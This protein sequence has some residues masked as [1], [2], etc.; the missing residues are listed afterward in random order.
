MADNTILNT[1]AGGD[2]VRDKD[3]AGVKTQ[4]VGIDVAI[5]SGTESLMTSTNGMPVR[6]AVVQQATNNLTAAAQAQTFTLQ[7]EAAMTVQLAGTWVGTVVFEA[8]NDNSN[9]STINA[10]RA[11][12]NTITQT[13]SNTAG[14]DVY[15]LG[16][17]G[18]LFVRTRC[19]AYTSGTI[20][21]T[22]ATSMSAATAVL[23]ASLPAGTAD[24]GG[25]VVGQRQFWYEANVPG[26]AAAV[27]AAGDQFGSLITIANAARI[28]GAGG[29]ITGVMLFD[30]DDL[31]VAADVIFYNDTVTPAADNAVFALS[32]ADGRKALWLCQMPY[33]ADMGA[34][35]AAQVVGVSVPYF[36][37]ATSL[38]A[39]IRT[40]SAVTPTAT[41][42]R[43]RVSMIRD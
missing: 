36:C 11:G 15:R 7:G 40:Q 9:W 43:I 32:D 2:S 22:S 16:I 30:D 20:V 29:F 25:V 28:T 38:Y 5:G 4:I 42:V 19:S 17:A 34:Q 6:S 26:I 3:R 39:L 23:S 14:D 24:I 10:Q 31:Q 12:D 13:V 41:G 8:S 18:F 35:R 1:G 33:F 27:Y 21:V 37:T